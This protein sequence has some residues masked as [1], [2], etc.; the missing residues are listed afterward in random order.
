MQLLTLEFTNRLREK[1]DYFC[2]D[3]RHFFDALPS[4]FVNDLT[5]SFVFVLVLTELSVTHA[6]QLAAFEMFL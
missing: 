4:L 2:Y 6:Y 3:R 1:S 5:A